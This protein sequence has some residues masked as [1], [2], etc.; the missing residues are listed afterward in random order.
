[1]GRTIVVQVCTGTTCYVLGGAQL[2]TLEDAL[3]GHLR[4]A[5][6]IEGINCIEAC[7]DESAGRPPFVTID[8]EVLAEASIPRVIE[9]LEDLLKR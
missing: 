8:G 6:R 4:E 3:P 2:L 1:M 7:R 5:V 9:R